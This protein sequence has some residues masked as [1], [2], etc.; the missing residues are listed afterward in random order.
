MYSMNTFLTILDMAEAVYKV[1]RRK[2]E[3]KVEGRVKVSSKRAASGEGETRLQ[4][5]SVLVLPY[6]RA[7]EGRSFQRHE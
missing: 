6:S 4:V 1:Q 7:L 5:T 2:L 3:F